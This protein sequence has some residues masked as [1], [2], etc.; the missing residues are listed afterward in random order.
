MTEL[1]F[2]T[3]EVAEMLHVDKS[4][5]KRWTDEGKLKCFRTPGGHRKFRAEDLQQ[6]MSDYNYTVS[7][8]DFFPRYA[9]DEAIIRGMISQKE[10]NVLDSVCFSAAIKGNKDE[11]VK[12]LSEAHRN[13]M[14]LPMVFDKILRPTVKKISD[15]HASGKLQLFEKQLALNSLANAIIVFSDVIIKAAPNGKRA[16]AAMVEG[17]METFELKALVVLLESQGYEVLSLGAGA[18]GESVAQLVRIK[19][20]QFVFLIATNRFEVNVVKEE[21]HKIQEELRAYDGRLIIGGSGYSDEILA[22]DLPGSFDVVCTSFK[23]FSNLAF[24]KGEM[25]KKEKD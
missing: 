4:T 22:K 24:E 2:T 13:G 9:S 11:L 7:P 6:F 20:P 21:H 15:L 8:T 5:V 25:K 23:E 3:K 10:F 18:S 17:D 14:S 1:L 19:H 16:I 12:L